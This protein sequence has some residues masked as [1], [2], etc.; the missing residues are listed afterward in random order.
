MEPKLAQAAELAEKSVREL[1][2]I[3]VAKAEVAMK[4]A[5]AS[6]SKIYCHE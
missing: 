4:M 2:T 6:F 3:K 5:S 1:E